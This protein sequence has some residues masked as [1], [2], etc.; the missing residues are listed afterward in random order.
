MKFLT[1]FILGGL[2][3]LSFSPYNISILA[4]LSILLFMLFINIDSKRLSII[5]SLFFSLG[6]FSVGTYWLQNV[7][8]NFA[9]INYFLTIIIIAIFTIYLSM[10]VVFPVIITTLL[11]QNLKINK[12]FLLII[13][14]ILITF[15]EIARGYMFSGFSWLNFGQAAINTPLDYFFPVFGVH[16]LTFI[17]FL[18][19]IIFI[20][21]IKSENRIFFISLSL[22]LVIIYLGIFN[23]NW[24]YLTKKDINVFIVQPNIKNKIIYSDNDILNRIKVLSDLTTSINHSETDIVLWPEAPLPITYNKLEN[25]VYKKILN[26]IPESTHLLIGT[27]YQDKK[28]I[29]NSIVNASDSSN[30][31]RKKHLVPFGEYL[32]FKDNLSFLYKILGM[33]LYDIK[34][35]VNNNSI[36]IKNFIAHALICY[37]SIFS[38]D[39]LVVNGQSDFIINVSNDGWFGDSLAPFQHLDSLIMR[40]LENQR[41]SIRSTNNGISAIIN[42]FGDIEEHIN[43]N[44][45]GVISKKIYARNGHTPISQHGYSILFIFIFSIFLYSALYFNIKTFKR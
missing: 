6:Y 13:L 22:I 1:F 9:D 5:Q 20:N 18:I 38:K 39:S 12:S 4:F 40:S 14:S 43:F 36:Q 19:S 26:S 25:T 11:N 15:F 10:F 35:G 29:Y 16:G 2:Y 41:Y 45:K 44:K 32:P 34:K 27:F 7:I 3:T 33:N 24:T 23:K 21:I 17:I 28:F 42:P 31:S 8:N 30:Q 37:E